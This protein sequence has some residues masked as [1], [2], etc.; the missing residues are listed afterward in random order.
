MNGFVA[1]ITGNIPV[2]SIQ[3]EGGGVVVKVGDFPLGRIMAP[4]AIGS[5]PVFK[6]VV[7]NVD[8]ARSTNGRKTGKKLY[9]LPFIVLPEMTGPAGLL[10]MGFR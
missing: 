8:V 4:K 5:T 6:L 1:F 10:C 3:P 9:L 7:V 2:F